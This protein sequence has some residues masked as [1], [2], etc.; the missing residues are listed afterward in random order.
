MLRFSTVGF[1]IALLTG[2]ASTAFSGVT[3]TTNQAAFSAAAGPTRLLNFDIAANG[4]A[5][6][7]H[8]AIDQQYAAFGVDV[9]PFNS[10]SPITLSDPQIFG[11]N[12]VSAPNQVETVPAGTYFGGGGLEVVFAQPTSAVGLYLGDVQFPGSAIA[13]LNGAGDV[14]AMYDLFDYLGSSG[15]QWKF[16]G[17][18]STDQDIAAMQLAFAWNE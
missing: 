7:N 17:F 14:I 2:S 5:I 15:F 10:G 6:G 3:V 4:S 8:I 12:A 9:N 1:V 18:V 11:F 13:L 16:L